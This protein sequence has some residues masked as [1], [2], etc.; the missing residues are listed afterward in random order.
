MPSSAKTIEDSSWYKY[1]RKS[2]TST[3]LEALQPLLHAG[4]ADAF[5]PHRCHLGSPS[6]PPSESLCLLPMWDPPFPGALIF[7]LDLCSHFGGA[8]L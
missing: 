8:I 2:L 7:F 5:S 6:P 1:M 4:L 3:F